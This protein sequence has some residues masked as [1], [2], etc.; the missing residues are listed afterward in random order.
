MINSCIDK[1]ND[2]T[3]IIDHLR[4][5]NIDIFD[6]SSITNELG[7][8]FSTIGNKYVNNI[9]NSNTS[10]CSYLNVIPRNTKSIYLTPTT[11]EE[12]RSLIS[13]LPNKKSSGFDNIDN[14]ILKEIKDCIS[15]K[16]SEIFNVSMLEGKFPENM[17]LAEVVPLYKSKE[18]FFMNNYR[19]ISLLIT[20]SKLLEKVIYKHTYSFLQTTRQ[21]CDSQYGFRQGHL[22]ENAISELVGEILK[23][24]ENNKFTVGLFLD[25]SKAFDLLKHSTL[26]N[27]MEIY[28]IRGIA[29]SWFSSYLDKRQLRAKCKTGTENSEVSQ[30]FDITYGTPQGLCLGPLLFIIFC[31]DL[32]LHLTYLSCIQFA[33]DTTLYSSGKSSRL[34][35]CE[36]NHDLEIISDWFRA[37]KLTLNVA[38]IVCMVFLPKK[39][40][41][42][43]IKVKLCNQVL[44][45]QTSTKF[46]GIQLNSNLDWSKHYSAIYSKLKQ[47]TGLLHRCKNFLTTST[48]RLL[49]FAHI[50]S[51]LSYSIL[52]WGSTM[53]QG[54]LADLQKIQNIC[55][56]LIKPNISVLDGFSKLKIPTVNQ[57]I[58]IELSLSYVNFFTNC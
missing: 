16:L 20:I 40:Q 10:I 12:I 31:N 32:K 19:P 14:I 26:L 4:V 13:K 56:K 43:Q 52:V 37:N 18:K 6:S 11:S 23:N 34:I 57:L 8:Y 47:N 30:N 42:N 36:I 21:L 44:P 33:D 58:N 15:P 53:K 38:K 35:E 17:K 9:R 24:K 51:H 48:L 3:T 49:Y 55:I 25:L 45:I 22:C 5:D 41:D 54:V 2:K 39:N 7:R 27:K 28:R 29:L 50:H 46:L 1:T